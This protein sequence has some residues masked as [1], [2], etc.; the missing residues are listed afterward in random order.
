MKRFVFG[1][2]AAICF[3]TGGSAAPFDLTGDDI[4]AIGQVRS[5]SVSTTILG[6]R[7]VGPGVEYGGSDISVDVGADTI[8]FT[9][10]NE[11]ATVVY[12][13]NGVGLVPNFFFGYIFESLDGG[14]PIDAVSFTTTGSVK[15]FF[16]NPPTP[17]ISFTDTTLTI[18]L[19]DLAFT[20][21]SS[22]TLTITGAPM[23]A[24]PVPPALAFGIAGLAFLGG[25][26][27]R[28]AAL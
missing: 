19:L 3:A 16:V 8:T 2:I 25:L 10:T 22:L 26:R 7:T 12:N 5:L 28:K 15:D 27:R 9:N 20:A 23:A 18:D 17:E 6:T 21:G 13:R 1:I 24:V 11:T 4:S 14:T